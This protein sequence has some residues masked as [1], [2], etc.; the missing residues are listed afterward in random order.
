MPTGAPNETVA[1]PTGRQGTR[2]FCQELAD[3][4]DR[5]VPVKKLGFSTRPLP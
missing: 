5:W 3:V 4:T 1:A 2:A